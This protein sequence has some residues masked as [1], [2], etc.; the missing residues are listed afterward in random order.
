MENCV[1]QKICFEVPSVNFSKIPGKIFCYWLSN[2]VLFHLEN[3]QKL[4]SYGV[5]RQGLS[6]SDNNRFLRFWHEVKLNNIGFF[7]KNTRDTIDYKWY[8]YNKAGNFRKWSSINEYVV[9]YQYDGK[10]IKETVMKKYPYLSGPGF[11]V[12][13]TDYYFRSGITWNDVASGSFS[14]RYIPE[15]FIFADAGPMYFSNDN[16]IMLAYFNT[17][18]FQVYADI[19]CQGLHYSTGHIPNIPYKTPQIEKQIQIEKIVNDNLSVSLQD[20]DSFETS[21]GFKKHPLV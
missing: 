20:W 9:N 11:V 13:N 18:V 8:P 3:G 21:W 5:A 7:C 19:I 17:K 4:G 10:E 2:N 12:K 16:F 15:G 6:T 1:I 14:C